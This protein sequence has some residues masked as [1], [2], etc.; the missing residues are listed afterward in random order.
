MVITLGLEGSAN[1]LGIGILKD[2]QILSNVRQT[3]VSRPGEGFRPGEAARHHYHNIVPLLK[4]AL[5]EAKV[6]KN[7]IDLICYT[8]GPGMGA[9]LASVAI[10]ARC[11]SIMWKRPLV[12]VN[13]CVAHIEMG[14]LVT[15]ARDP[16]FLYVSGGNTQVIAGVTMDDDARYRIFGE[17]IDMAVGNCIDRLAR[18]LK[19]SNDP[20][21]GLNVERL[22]AQAS[23]GVLIDLPYCVKG[24]DVSFSGIV[25]AFE[26][27][28]QEGCVFRGKKYSAEEICFSVQ[29]TIFAMLVEIT[30]RTMAHV[31]SNEVLVVGGVG[32]NVRL[33]EMMR[34]MCEQRGAMSFGTDER[35]CV[36]NGAMIAFTGY[37]MFKEFGNDAFVSVKNSMITQRFRTDDVN[38]RWLISDRKTKL[39]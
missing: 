14:K 13:H 19:L 29:E 33:Q 16:V 28:I 27:I 12:P 8:K 3:Y 5:D 10:V 18:A 30:E 2:D 15:S 25:T 7:D 35:Y 23:N 4:K 22:A 24:M 21:P 31:G 36:D 9:S 26:K 11:L 6:T 34:L 17:T 32:C 38:A 1:K 37:K 20:A 39:V